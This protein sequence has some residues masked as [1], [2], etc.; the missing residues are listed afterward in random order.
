MMSALA[1]LTIAFWPQSL[2]E[3]LRARELNLEA[4]AYADET[5]YAEAEQLYR[6]SLAIEEAELGPD[7]IEIAKTMSTLQDVL[8]RQSKY[9]DAEPFARRA[10]AIREQSLGRDH[11][12]V[13]YSL[14]NL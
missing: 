14:N 11:R 13:G 8:V 3:L 2:N 9:R 10:L 6:Q 12:D 4:A 1:A 5:R 7:D